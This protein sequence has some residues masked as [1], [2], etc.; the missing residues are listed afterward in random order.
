MGHVQAS[1]TWLFRGGLGMRLV[2]RIRDEGR[3]GE[4]E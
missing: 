4:R 3:E 2:C 1:F